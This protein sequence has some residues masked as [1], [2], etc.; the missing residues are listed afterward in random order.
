MLTQ[1]MS[2]LGHDFYAK[3]ALAA[4]ELAEKAVDPEIRAIHQR[5]SQD[6]AD[7]ARLTAPRKPLATT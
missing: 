4:R 2:G 7:L 6:Y 5:M 1:G 3:R